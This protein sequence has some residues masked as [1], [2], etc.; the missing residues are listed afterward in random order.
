[1]ASASAASTRAPSYSSRSTAGVGPAAA[2]GD[3][4]EILRKYDP[5]FSEI[6]FTDFIYTLYARVHEA[7]GRNALATYSPY[8]DAD[9]IEH[10]QA[11]SGPRLKEVT[12]VIVGASRI[13]AVSN[14]ERP[15]IT[16]SVLFEANYTEASTGHGTA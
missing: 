7:R 16:I 4:F 3:R 12:G 6:L 14:P 10:L 11:L 5:N 9:V 8:L 15:T 13:L 1:T 2:E